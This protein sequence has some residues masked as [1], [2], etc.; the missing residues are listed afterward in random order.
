MSAVRPHVT[1]IHDLDE[2]YE[3][4]QVHSRR[5]IAGTEIR[6]ARGAYVETASWNA[7]GDR[8]RYLL[9]IRAVGE[10]RN[11]GMPLSHWSAAAIHG[12]PIIGE[13]P[14]RVH[15]TVGKVS[16]GRSRRAVVK[17]ALAI[18]DD[19]V[20][21]VDGLL[22]TSVARTVVDMAAKCGFLTSTMIVDRALLVDRW[23]RVQ[24]LTSREELWTTYRRRGN[25]VGARRA[26]RIISFGE[27]GAESP[28]ESVSRA[29]MRY[30]RCPP[31]EL[32]VSFADHAGQIG[33]ADFHWPEFRIVGE[34]D[35]RVKYLDPAIRGQRT[36]E[37]VFLDEKTRE[38]RIRAV[39]ERVTRWPWRV[40][41][42]AALLRSHLQR[43]G[44]P[45]P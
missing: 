37:Q 2:L 33:F 7:L 12:L 30:L 18:P 13:W 15:L 29:N 41:V 27:T 38:D 25:F 35:G 26:E 42:D 17:H 34:A 22:V 11:H 39:G 32:Q 40:G 9:A 6:L 10:T 14:H 45:I 21:E 19:D 36:A 43:A 23:N 31:P 20:V 1:F 28:L 3:Q 4:R 5:A 8:E 16:G 24:P 44:I